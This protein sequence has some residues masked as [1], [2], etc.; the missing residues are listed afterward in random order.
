MFFA[1][2]SETASKTT[3]TLRGE[4]PALEIWNPH[5]GEREA[6]AVTVENGTTSFTLSM[7]RV[8]SLFV[9][10]GTGS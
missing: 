6:L 5:T 7:A 8:S 2:S 9:V 4:F 10:E 1:N 3:V